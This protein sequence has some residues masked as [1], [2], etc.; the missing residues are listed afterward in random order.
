MKILAFT[1][2]HDSFSALKKIEHKIKMKN[3]D[4]LVCAGDISI[5]E[6]GLVKIMKK[7][8]QLGKKI[9]IING[10]HEDEDSFAKHSKYLKNLI[11]IHKNHYIENDVLFLGFGGGGFSLVDKEFERFS[12][13]FVKLI[14]ENP[15][16]K[17]ILLTHAPPYKTNTDKIGS[18]HCG[19][20]SIRNF[21]EKNRI[22]YLF[23]GHLHENF[24]KEDTIKK[25]KVVN[26][27]NYG[28]IFV[29]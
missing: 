24:G 25:T 19:N 7:M 2:I 3:P 11:F 29:V 10:N 9:V 15:D 26:P 17:V 6:R 21:I 27:G 13:K 1:D 5:F 28:K 20:K 18:E 14:K 16:K 22:D 4:I 23:C 8:N 12:P